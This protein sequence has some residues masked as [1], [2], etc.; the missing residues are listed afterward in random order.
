[1]LNEATSS[2]LMTFQKSDK[3]TGIK[4]MMQKT[5]AF[6]M[7]PGE[8]RRRQSNNRCRKSNQC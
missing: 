4:V 7:P 8:D 5:P 6:L 3:A 1:M 2:R